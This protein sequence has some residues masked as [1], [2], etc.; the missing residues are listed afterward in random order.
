MTSKTQT[1]PQCGSELS[2]RLG[3]YECAQ[4]GYKQ[5]TP[6]GP[7]ER[8]GDRIGQRREAWQ[9]DRPIRRRPTAV[10]APE[11]RQDLDFEPAGRPARE[12][13]TG[14]DLEKRL[15]FGISASVVVIGALGSIV[16]VVASGGSLS[17]VL[18]S[19]FW[20]AVALFLLAYV[21]FAGEA[22]ARLSCAVLIA[23]ELLALIGG[24]YI[25]IPYISAALGVSWLIPSFITLPFWIAVAVRATW[26]G[27]LLS[28]L[29]RDHTGA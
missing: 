20:D 6:V 26:Y 15:Y 1:C 25:T 14:L 16:S 2:Y 28:I 4:C 10:A 9:P 8:A 18:N 23:L 7:N 27:W 12:R 17:W 3:I 29:W 11:A 22:W 24:A 5:E 13:L 19:L 21:L